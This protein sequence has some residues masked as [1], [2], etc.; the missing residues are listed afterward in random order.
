M[1]SAERYSERSEES[2]VLPLLLRQLGVAG[3]REI[4]RCALNDVLTFYAN[5]YDLAAAVVR[6]FAGDLHVVGVRLAQAGTRD[7]CEAGLL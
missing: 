1:R 6:C 7:A 2:C 4:L 3:A 5:G